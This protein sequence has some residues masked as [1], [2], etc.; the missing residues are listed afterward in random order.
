[1]FL[2]KFLPVGNAASAELVFGQVVGRVAIHHVAQGSHFSLAGFP[3]GHDF[4]AAA[5]ALEQRS[6]WD[7]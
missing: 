5:E 4:G 6:L 3:P 2:S 1:M 7:G